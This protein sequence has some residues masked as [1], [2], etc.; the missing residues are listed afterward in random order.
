MTI[1]TAGEK[2]FALTNEITHHVPVQ[3]ASP[4]AGNFLTIVAA[5]TALAALWLLTADAGKLFARAL[6]LRDYEMCVR[7][8]AL[9]A[10]VYFLM[11]G[12][13]SYLATRYGLFQEAWAKGGGSLT[14][15]FS[16]LSAW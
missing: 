10:P 8:T 13:F 5:F 4:F 7:L 9:Y 3:P 14:A 12:A 2:T 6:A 15:S 1:G 16:C 11:F